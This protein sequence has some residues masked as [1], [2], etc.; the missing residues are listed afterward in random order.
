M[1]FFV[2]LIIGN[3]LSPRNVEPEKY[4]NVRPELINRSDQSL[5]I[6][7]LSNQPKELYSV[8]E[9]RKGTWLLRV[10]HSNRYEYNF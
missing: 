6:H 2:R 7:S 4:N 9:Y 8:C 1:T 5:V 10:L 3:K